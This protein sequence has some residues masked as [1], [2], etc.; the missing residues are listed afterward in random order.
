[1]TVTVKELHI[2]GAFLMRYTMREA[3]DLIQSQ[4]LPLEHVVSHV[5]PLTEIHRGI[6]LANAGQGIKIVFKP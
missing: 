4:K 5:L 3:L 1:M 6:E 2:V